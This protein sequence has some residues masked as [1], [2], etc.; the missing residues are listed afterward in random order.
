M[1]EILVGIN[2]ADRSC[3]ITCIVGTAVTCP[4]TSI[5]TVVTSDVLGLMKWHLSETIVA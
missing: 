3:I 1:E 2:S 5:C 4:N